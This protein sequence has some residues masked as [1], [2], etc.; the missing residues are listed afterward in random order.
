MAEHRFKVGDKVWVIHSGEIYMPL[1]QRVP[2]M[3][4]DEQSRF[5]RIYE[6]PDPR[7]AKSYRVCEL[8]G[9]LCSI[10]YHESS[11]MSEAEKLFL[12]STKG[13]SD[14]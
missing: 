13:V 5:V 10:M 14:E 2:R 4:D 8:N 12:D 1:G 11:M 7:S 3:L 6:E 9:R